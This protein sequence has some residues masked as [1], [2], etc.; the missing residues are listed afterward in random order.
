MT[1]EGRDANYDQRCLEY[2]GLP[3]TTTGI[4]AQGRADRQGGE[5]GQEKT[6]NG[7]KRR[8]RDGR[9]RERR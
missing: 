2:D 6:A 8:L 1:G 7:D 5:T 3:I 4:P 9:T